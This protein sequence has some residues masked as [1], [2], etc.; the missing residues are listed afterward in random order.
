MAFYLK[1]NQSILLYNLEH[2]PFRVFKKVFLF[3]LL[4]KDSQNWFAGKCQ[5]LLLLPRA[6]GFEFIWIHSGQHEFLTW[7]MFCI[8]SFVLPILKMTVLFK[9]GRT[10]DHLYTYPAT[11]STFKMTTVFINDRHIYSIFILF[12]KEFGWDFLSIISHI[13]WHYFY[14]STL[15]F[16]ILMLQTIYRYLGKFSLKIW[17]K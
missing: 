3:P 17:T 8:F 6:Y 10:K 12:R 15:C 11:F 4:L 1:Q 13:I 7:D 14:R 9:E 2:L 16:Y 5:W